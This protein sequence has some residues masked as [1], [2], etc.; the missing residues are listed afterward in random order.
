MKAEN[1]RWW[2]RGSLHTQTQSQF[3][4]IQTSCCRSCCELWRISIDLLITDL[5]LNADLRQGATT[6]KHGVEEHLSGLI[7]VVEL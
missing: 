5:C 3:G 6:T 2:Q 7:V 4:N 1:V